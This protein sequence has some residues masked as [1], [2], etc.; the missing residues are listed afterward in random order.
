MLLLALACAKAPEPVD[1]APQTVPFSRTLA[2]IDLS[3]QDLGG[4]RPARSILHL[5]SPWSHD[6]CDGDPLP[7]G[8]PNAS[9]LA[10]LRAAICDVG[11]DLASLTDHPAHAAAQPYDTLSWAAEGDA[12]ELL[13]GVAVGN[14]V[15]C[16]DGSSVLVLPGIEDTLMPLGLRQHVDGDAAAREALYNRR[17]DEAI[18]A[19]QATGA[20]LTLAH[21]E[22]EALGELSRLQDAG[23]V[24]LE[25]F[26]LHAMVDPNLREDFLGLDGLTWL[27]DIADFTNPDGTAEP[28]LLFLAIVQE[29]APSVLAWDSLSA[30]GPAFG[31]AG[32][33]AHQNVLPLTLR[34][35]ERGDSYRR[36]MRWFS[37]W[38]LLSP[39]E[40][41]SAE[42][43]EAAQRAGRSYIVFEAFG[44]PADFDVALYDTAGARYEIGAD[45]PPGELRVRCPTLAARSPRGPTPPEVSARVLRDGQPF[46][47][48]C[49]AHTVT[50]P[51]VYRVVFDI[52]PH[53]LSP[54]LGEDP[55]K[56]VHEAV[57]I[58]ANPHRVR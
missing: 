24:G 56:H 12:P 46:A 49:G 3:E 8:A 28:D 39:G 45:A 36:M 2:R 21:T 38:L 30:R 55:D 47:E 48:G 40:A 43:I 57:W 54:F 51:G 41:V 9:C 32:T 31:F 16:P 13:N 29:Q 25:A 35:G 6:A 58:Y 18:L 17:D 7:D 20:V 19:M 52:T 10:D 27:S 14:H 50:E 22:Q 37:N 42:A 23:L 5:H 33:D 11:L 1:T 4:H 26:N 15:A 44:T 53:H 34:D